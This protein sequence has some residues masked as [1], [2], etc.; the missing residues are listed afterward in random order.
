MTRAPTQAYM[1]I[2]PEAFWM[3]G[4]DPQ[5]TE[6]T[7]TMANARPSMRRP[8]KRALTAVVVCVMI[9]VSLVCER[10]ARQICTVDRGYKHLSGRSHDL[11]ALAASHSIGASIASYRSPSPARHGSP[12]RWP[13]VAPQWFRTFSRCHGSVMRGPPGPVVNPWNP[14][15]VGHADP[16]YPFLSPYTPEIIGDPGDVTFSVRHT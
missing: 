13:G 3:C 9:S 16:G 2:S 11:S 14:S 1:V 12:A 4:S 5:V 6:I 10:C 8:R 7:S 15:S